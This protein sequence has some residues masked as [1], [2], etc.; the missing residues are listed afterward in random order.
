MVVH[1]RSLVL[2]SELASVDLRCWR[3]RRS[4][5]AHCRSAPSASVTHASTDAEG[6]VSTSSLS[7]SASA[8]P[9]RPSALGD[10]ENRL[11]PNASCLAEPCWQPYID[12][13]RRAA[14]GDRHATNRSGRRALPQSASTPVPRNA[15]PGRDR[16]H[17][18]AV[19][20]LWPSGPAEAN[21]DRLFTIS[22]LACDSGADDGSPGCVCL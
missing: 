14:E 13:R 15:Y 2:A 3:L 16:A 19:S 6:R 12:G 8:A 10:A 1:Q 5:Q 21:S 9:S 7:L 11:A 17:L 4:D 18:R 20:R 22:R